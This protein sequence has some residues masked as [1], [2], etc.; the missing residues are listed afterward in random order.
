MRF[1]SY[2]MLPEHNVK[3]FTSIEKNNIIFKTCLLFNK[4]SIY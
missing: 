1:R 3:R 4:Y 2:K